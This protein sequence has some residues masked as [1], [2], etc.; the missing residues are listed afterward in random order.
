MFTSPVVSAIKSVFL[1]LV[2]LAGL[3]LGGLRAQ[4]QPQS[5]TAG[6]IV[7]RLGANGVPLDKGWKFHAGDDPAWA[8]ADFDDR[9]WLP[10]N[11]VRPRRLLPWRAQR[12]IGWLRLRFRL[13]DSLRQRALLLR[14]WQQGEA[15]ELY[16][17][18]QLVQR[19]GIVHAVPARVHPAGTFHEPVELPVGRAEQVLAVRLVPWEPPYLLGLLENSLLRVELMNGTQYRHR[20]AGYRSAGINF[21]VVAGIYGLLTLLHFAFFRYN[22]AQR[23]NLYFALYALA[24]TL[25]SVGFF[26][27]WTVPLPELSSYVFITVLSWTLVVLSSLA[28]VRAQY[29]LFGFRPGKLYAGLWVSGVVLLVSYALIIMSGADYFAVLAFMALTIAEQ[30]HITVRALR[31]RRRG[32]WIIGTGFGCELLSVVVIVVLLATKAD[33]SVAVNILFYPLVLLPPALSISLFLGREFALD[34]RLLQVK[35]RE[36]E[37][38][39]AQT[40]AQEQEKQALL[41]QQNEMLEHQVNQR[42]RE[43]QRSLSDLRTTQAQ[44]LQKEK[45]A[46]LGELTAGIAHEIQ[47]PLNFVNNFAEV[48]AELVA[49]LREEQAKGPAADAALQEEIFEDLAQNLGKI[50]HHGQRAA[51]IVRG[52]L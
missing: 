22:P 24:L 10:I 3:P 37:Q 11:P 32:A 33:I 49:E 1:L 47:N 30:L 7:R 27:G 45:M 20:S 38:L 23:A 35:L 4:P 5:D 12:G 21:I 15:F 13:S 28:V 6:V 52:M 36:V 42:T 31:Q 51:G 39:S 48:S 14:A 41:A 8:R 9:A 2:L 46:S 18:G 26:Y 29:A 50:S 34:S 17:N 19:A 43:L 25:A 44:L 40:L 16:L